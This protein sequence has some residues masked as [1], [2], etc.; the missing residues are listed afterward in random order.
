VS[1]AVFVRCVAVDF[2]A[3]DAMISAVPA[4]ACY[5]AALLRRARASFARLYYSL[6]AAALAGSLIWH[7]VS[8]SMLTIAWGLEAVALLGAGFP[9]RD[10]VLR[11]TGLALLIG[12][13]GKLFIWD[14]RNLD[15]LPRILS[16]VVLGAL[17]VA[18]SWVY[19]RFRETVQRYL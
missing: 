19:T 1:A 17:L 14:L 5:V 12:C 3:P 11:L 16:F 6:A 9:L 10:R 18:V 7:E 4:V 8:G 13:I 2:G 15:P